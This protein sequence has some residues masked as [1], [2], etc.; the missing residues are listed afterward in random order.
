MPRPVDPEL[1]AR[2]SAEVLAAAR[3]HLT[4]H[5]PAG[6]S[7]RAVAGRLG[8]APN[9]VYHYYPSID[10]LIT[11][12]LIDAHTRLAEAVWAGTAGLDGDPADVLPDTLSARR[13]VPDAGRWLDR[14]L[15]AC[16]AYRS[17]AVAH[18]TD[19]D[20]IFG[21]PLPDYVAPAD[22]TAELP[23]RT[24]RAGLATVAGADRAGALRPP[25]RYR[26]PP[27]AVA[28][29]MVRNAAAIGPLVSPTAYFV[30]TLAWSRLHGMVQ[31]ENHGHYDSAVGDPAAF[32]RHA[33]DALAEEIGLTA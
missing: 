30:M 33:I 13:A 26:D 15:G 19:Y 28:D 17:W 8:L 14:F 11:A 9:S 10:E 29:Q 6:F 7:L 22:R 18:R 20:L 27:R 5:G 2:R 21:K 4:A 31:L 1:H 32:Y 3:T 23:L 25:P 24:F 16:S 12:L